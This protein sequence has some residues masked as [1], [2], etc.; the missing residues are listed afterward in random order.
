[1]VARIPTVCLLLVLASLT[2]SQADAEDIAVGDT[3][4]VWPL[5]G[6]LIAPTPTPAPGTVA[7]PNPNTCPETIEHVEFSQLA[8]V[9]ETVIYSVDFDRIKL[10][11]EKCSDRDPVKDRMLIIPS[12]PA[13]STLTN[14]PEVDTLNLQALFSSDFAGNELQ[15]FV[16]SL[17]VGSFLLGFD[18]GDRSCGDQE[19]P[20]NTP[21]LFVSPTDD[22]TL[23]TAEGVVI[24]GGKD[25]MISVCMKPHQSHP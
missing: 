24:K 25:N 11:G 4:G 14:I 15:S 8:E 16:D 20:A 7:G 23:A 9:E 2:Q 12:K 17:T 19:T 1:M 10:D 3:T 18:L 6:S 22:K 13:I 21:Y 5:A